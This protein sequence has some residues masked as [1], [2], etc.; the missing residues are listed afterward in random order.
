MAKGVEGVIS[1]D[2]AKEGNGSASI[3]IHAASKD[4][5]AEAAAIL[6]IAQLDIT[7]PM[8]VCCCV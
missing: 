4:A 8:Y 5:A 1:I 7:V 2:C 6:D 3:T